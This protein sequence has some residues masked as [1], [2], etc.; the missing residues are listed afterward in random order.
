MKNL[1]LTF[2]L[3]ILTICLVK[4]MNMK[5]FNQTDNFEDIK[6]CFT[7]DTKN[8][9][10]SA[11]NIFK[12]FLGEVTVILSAQLAREG[13]D[14][15]EGGDIDI[16]IKGIK[17]AIWNYFLYL[18]AY[19]LEKYYKGII[20]VRPSNYMIK[21]NSSQT[22]VKYTWPMWKFMRG[23][24]GKGQP[25]SPDEVQPTF[26]GKYEMATGS[27][28]EPHTFAPHKTP[29]LPPIIQTFSDLKIPNLGGIFVPI[30]YSLGISNPNN[31][32]DG[33][34]CSVNQ[35]RPDGDAVDLYDLDGN[36][37]WGDVG[38]CI[39]KNL[40]DFKSYL[41]GENRL[42]TLK[43]LVE[44][45]RETTQETWQARAS[46]EV[47]P[48]P[49]SAGLD[50]VNLTR[51]CSWS[52]VTSGVCDWNPSQANGTRGHGRGLPG[53]SDSFNYHTDATGYASC[54]TESKASCH[55][56]YGFPTFEHINI[57]PEA[58]FFKAFYA[59]STADKKKFLEG[60]NVM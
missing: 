48:T 1:I 42:Y 13:K 56:V 21:V 33:G 27:W 11:D 44:R 24:D 49:D 46:S 52:G 50:S 15:M 43:D 55:G 45:H 25:S 7:I 9:T 6:G 31:N 17:T 3:I 18:Y 37:D 20:I 32:K 26:D 57:I 53:V 58:T 30:G 60:M 51:S 54:Y 41:G 16:M 39:P 29:H 23:K 8:P 47:D 5:V 19:N 10:S 28:P 2:I 59:V 12:C 38:N 35:Y 22:V 36:S 40:R 14:K 34:K 4:Q